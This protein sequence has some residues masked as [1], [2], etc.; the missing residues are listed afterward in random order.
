MKPLKYLL[1]LLFLGCQASPEPAPGPSP[2][3]VSAMTEA[4]EELDARHAALIAEGVKLDAEIARLEAERRALWHMIANDP[5][6]I[7][8][9]RW[10]VVGALTTTLSCPEGQVVRSLEGSGVPLLEGLRLVCAPLDNLGDDVEL[11]KSEVFGELGE[12][13]PETSVCRANV[14]VGLAIEADAALSRVSV[15]CQRRHGSWVGIE[16]GF[17]MRLLCPEG[18]AMN[19]LRLGGEGLVVAL[20]P[21]CGVDVP[22]LP[23]IAR[24]RV[25]RPEPQRASRGGKMSRKLY[26][27]LLKDPKSRPPLKVQPVY[28]QSRISGFRV[29]GISRS[30]FYHDL[31]VRNGDVIRKVNGAAVDTPK[32][33]LHL[34]KGLGDGPVKVEIDRRG[35]PMTLTLELEEP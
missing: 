29:L 5:A 3:A 4:I 14:A 27:Q 25:R 13:E 23:K 15:R 6:G 11:W 24:E 35:R 2:E 28:K 7:E 32:K 30:S 17:P 22:E 26:D 12:E 10:G 33:V 20:E 16:G 31:G 19:G 34:Y 8:L 9:E 21:V 18:K 1:C